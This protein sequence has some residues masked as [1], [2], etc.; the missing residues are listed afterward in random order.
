MP[1]NKSGETPSPQN[2]PGKPIIRKDRRDGTVIL[3][4]RGAPSLMSSTYEDCV[5]SPVPSDASTRG[6]TRQR[7]DCTVEGRSSGMV[8]E[9]DETDNEE[10]IASSVLKLTASLRYDRNLQYYERFI[11]APRE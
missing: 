7:S 3:A 5:P 2:Y 6:L 4:P 8:P 9:T 10:W 1:K 11:K